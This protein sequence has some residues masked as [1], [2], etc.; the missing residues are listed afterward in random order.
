MEPF[1]PN[2]LGGVARKDDVRD[3][4]LGEAGVPSYPATYTQDAAF[5]APIYFQGHRPACGAHAGVWLKTLIDIKSGK[6]TAHYT[7]RFTWIDLKKDGSNPS[8]GTDMRSIF[9]SLASTGVDDFEPLENNVTYGDA[10]YANKKFITSAMTAMA[11]TNKLGSA[12]A[13][14]TPTFQQIKQNIFDHGAALLLIRIGDEFWTNAKGQ[15]DWSEAGVCPL[16]VPSPVVSGHFIVAHS[17]DENYIYF[18]NSFGPTWGR[19]GHGYFGIN[20][21]PWVVEAGTGPAVTAPNLV[22]PTVNQEIA[23]VVDAVK[24]LPPQQQVNWL[25]KLINILFKSRG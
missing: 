11:A 22:T 14:F 2:N 20:Y 9:K 18:A 4:I 15:V 10:D 7:P 21:M 16:R 1:I 6:Q 25:Q 5:A 3:Y 13:F 12:Y 19:K 24:T 23:Q 17:Y 8:D